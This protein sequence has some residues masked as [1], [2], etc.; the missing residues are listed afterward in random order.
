MNIR[1]LLSAAAVSLAG[2]AWPAHADG[3][4][5]LD[6]FLREVG[7]ARADFT[8]VV[9]SPKKSG[10]AAPRQRTSSG[11]FE[12]L[13]PDRFRFVYAKPFEQTIVAD[14]QRLWLHDVDLNQVTVRAQKD[15]LGSTPAALIASGGDLSS[16][17]AAFDFKALP[18]KDGLQ[19]VEAVPKA[20]DGQLQRVRVGLRARQLAV[21]DIEDG[22]GQRSELTFKGW[23]ANPGLATGDFRFE[24]PAGADVIRQ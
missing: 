18:D 8:Q 13:R 16:L 20:R 6:T 17:R 2:L 22:L 1:T 3:L 7:S 21:L 24:P 14:G 23:Q 10:E 9:T 5:A 12:F 15:A 19:W 11:R 4:Q